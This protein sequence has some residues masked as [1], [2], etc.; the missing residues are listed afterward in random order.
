MEVKLTDE[1]A[2]PEYM[3]ISEKVVHLRRL[4][5]TY[6]DIAGRLGVNR[7]MA[8]RAASLGKLFLQQEKSFTSPCLS[9]RYIAQG[10][11]LKAIEVRVSDYAEW[12]GGMAPGPEC[13]YH[14]LNAILLQSVPLP[15]KGVFLSPG[16]YVKGM[17]QAAERQP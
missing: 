15:L 9:N 13:N 6:D 5:A 7:W 17:S 3:K 4:G 8:L 16:S 2:V 1:D 14:G 12:A 10:R 11:Q